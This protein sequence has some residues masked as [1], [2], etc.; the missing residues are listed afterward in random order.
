[1]SGIDTVLPP[2]CVITGEM[3]D[4]QGMIAP[5]AWAQLEFIADPKCAQCGFPF[6]FEVEKGSLCASCIDRPPPFKTVRSALKYNDASRDLVLGFKHADKLHS[7]LAFIPWLEKAG[8]DMLEDADFLV[9]V[10]L[11]RW[12]LLGRRYNQSAIIGQELSKSTK[13]PMIV[14]AIK[15][16]R[17]TPSQGYLKAAERHKNV[18]H[19][20]AMNSKR[21]EIMKGKTVV[22]IDDVFTTGATV[23]ECTKTL[24][25]AGV[26][27]VHI[28]TL[29]R[30]IREG[31]G[32]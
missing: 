3:V 22:I 5:E 31:F 9:P 11:H 18:K 7:V 14:D 12:R 21:Q 16:I 30:T 25:K 2:R 26:K 20:F 1:M 19:A 4:K 6:E 32:G 8:A 15:R 28:L 13:I 29:T 10:P 24:L 17:A 23:K 27:E